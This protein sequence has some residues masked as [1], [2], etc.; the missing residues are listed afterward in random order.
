MEEMKLMCASILFFVYKRQFR[1][2][3]KNN[4]IL[5]SESLIMQRES[6]RRL[7]CASGGKV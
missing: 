6:C 3:P 2:L 4:A 1:F 7:V 5:F